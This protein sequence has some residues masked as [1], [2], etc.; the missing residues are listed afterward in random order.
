MIFWL[1]SKTVKC[2]RDS[3][4]NAEVIDYDKIFQNGGNTNE[5]NISKN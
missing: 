4:V 1:I 2:L 5:N 3:C